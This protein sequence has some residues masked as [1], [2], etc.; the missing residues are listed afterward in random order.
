M[1]TSTVAY[2]HHGPAWNV[3]TNTQPG[4]PTADS[5]R[6]GNTNLP[7]S[8]IVAYSIGDPDGTGPLTPTNLNTITFYAIANQVYTIAVGG[9]RNGDWFDTTDGYVL[10]VSQAPVPA[11]KFT[12]TGGLTG[13]PSALTLLNGLTF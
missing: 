3:G 5:L 4:A 13:V 11:C 8:S 12:A 1:D 6:G 7:L 2:N 10:T 9:Y